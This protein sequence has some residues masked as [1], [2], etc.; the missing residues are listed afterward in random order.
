[1][2]GG[3]NSLLRT[4][5]VDKKLNYTINR[6]C[7]VIERDASVCSDTSTEGGGE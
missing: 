6:V 7:L 3:A 5:L 4:E 2:Q 1:M